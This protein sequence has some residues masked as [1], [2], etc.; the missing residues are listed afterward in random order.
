MSH[1]FLIGKL[2]VCKGNA[3]PGLR[4]TYGNLPPCFPNRKPVTEPAH[5]SL[6]PVSLNWILELQKNSWRWPGFQLPQYK[7]GTREVK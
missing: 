1:T 3:Q 7:L 2:G 4:M 5:W 6:S